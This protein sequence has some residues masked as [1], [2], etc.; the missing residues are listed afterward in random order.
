MPKKYYLNINNTYNTFKHVNY[1]YNIFLI[2]T[3]PIKIISKFIAENS[4]VFKQYITKYKQILFIFSFY[5]LK[6]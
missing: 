2:L 1:T 6:K 5:C 4:Q 3:I